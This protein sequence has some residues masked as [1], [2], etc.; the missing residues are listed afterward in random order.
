MDLLVKLAKQPR[1]KLKQLLRTRLPLLKKR[2]R[3]QTPQPIKSKINLRRPRMTLQVV[4]VM[5]RL[6]VSHYLKRISDQSRSLFRSRKLRL[7]SLRKA[8]RST[9]KD[10]FTN[11]LKMKIPSKDIRRRSMVPE[12]SLFLNLLRIF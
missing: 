10:L 8:L 4:A 7:K 5:K 1:T 11:L 9:R 3:K 12:N 2:P 6:L